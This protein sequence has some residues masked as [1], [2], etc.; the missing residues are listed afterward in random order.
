MPGRGL[1]DPEVHIDL[2]DL[3]GIVEVPVDLDEPRYVDPLVRDVSKFA[4][5]LAEEDR[6]VLLGSVAT[7]KY[8]G[9]L[10]PILSERLVIPDEFVGRGDMSRGG[11]MLR[12]VDAGEELSY[13]PVIGARRRGRRPPKLSPRRLK[14]SHKSKGS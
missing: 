13:S 11:L 9:P 5:L 6:V 8:V 2:D 12:C 1:M 14:R 7:D 3:R 10:L 4:G